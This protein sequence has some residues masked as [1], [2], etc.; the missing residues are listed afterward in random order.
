MVLSSASA[1]LLVPT[2][3]GKVYAFRD[4]GTPVW[5]HELDATAL[6][7]PNIHTPSGQTTPVMSTA[8]FAASN[9]RLYAVIVDGQLDA[10][11]PWP[12]AFHD[13]RNTNRAGPQ[14]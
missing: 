8:Y 14:P 3:G 9:G 5:S 11:A 6:R 10:A 4:D 13:P 2:A 1:T 12:K 7:A